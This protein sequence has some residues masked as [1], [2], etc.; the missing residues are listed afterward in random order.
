MRCEDLMQRI[1][2]PSGSPEGLPA[3]REL[4][5]HLSACPECR[6]RWQEL[7]DAESI[8]VTAPLVAPP[9]GFSQRVMLRVAA[10]RTRLAAPQNPARTAP[11]VAVVASAVAL[12]F[13]ATGAILISAI[14]AWNLDALPSLAAHS[15]VLA[16]VEFFGML[17]SLDALARAIAVVWRSLPLTTIPAAL[18][19]ASFGA[20]LAASVWAWLVTRY[21]WAP[22]STGD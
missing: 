5:D 3:N 17:V 4:A 21:G 10:E 11:R 18:C 15:L 14:L 2:P 19:A 20:F 6:R 1:S 22:R 9:D 8:L 13:V 16:V 7:R 12:S